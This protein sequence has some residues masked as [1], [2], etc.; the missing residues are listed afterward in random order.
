MH[1]NKPSSFKDH[2][3]VTQTQRWG[4]SETLNTEGQRPARCPTLHCAP[5]C[6]YC[7]PAIDWLCALLLWN[8][9]GCWKVLSTMAGRLEELREGAHEASLSH[10]TRAHSDRRRT[11]HSVSGKQRVRSHLPLAVLRCKPHSKLCFL[12]FFSMLFIFVQTA[13]LRA[14]HTARSHHHHHRPS[15]NSNS[16]FK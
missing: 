6:H 11:T 15:W 3:F 1:I 13:L 7:E 14:S 9:R 4:F 16:D 10:V 12:A 2:V 5:L 8:R